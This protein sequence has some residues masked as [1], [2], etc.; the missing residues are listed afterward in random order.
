MIRLLF[1][2][3]VL[4]LAASCYRG[5]YYAMF[6]GKGQYQDVGQCLY[7]NLGG[8]ED[9]IHFS[10]NNIVDRHLIGES[11]ENRRY[12]I[13]SKVLHN[14][15][16]LNGRLVIEVANKIVVYQDETDNIL[17][18]VEHAPDWSFVW[19]TDLTSLLNDYIPACV[20]N[21]DMIRAR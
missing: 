14:D 3:T 2:I 8:A 6:Q 7:Q 13:R 9:K 15:S 10:S 5:P 17:V 18:V 12:V 19:Q 4:L 21:A 11:E 1:S 16:D 20:E